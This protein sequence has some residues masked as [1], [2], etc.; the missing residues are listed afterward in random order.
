MKNKI[1]RLTIYLIIT[2]LFSVNLTAQKNA[3]QVIKEMQKKFTGLK[4]FDTEFLQIEIWDL[5]GKVDTLRG[6]LSHMKKDYFKI[7][8]DG[9]I[10][11]TD[12]E[13]VWDYNIPER[14]III[15]KFDKSRDSFIIRDYLFDFPKRFITVDFRAEERGGKQGYYLEMEPKKPDEETIQ[16]LA[17]WI[18]AADFIVKMAKYTDFNDNIV[19]FIL[20]NF[21]ADTG[22]S[23]DDF[24]LKIP[25]GVK[26]M[27]LTKGN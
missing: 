27:D 10:L 17:V 15:D 22:L 25:E 8:T 7:E 14:Q 6:R 2:T 24:I 13:K 16:E 20:Q 5:Y 18:D 11:I 9:A 26:V 19:E 21:K 23:K 12:G 3:N 1:L 4:D